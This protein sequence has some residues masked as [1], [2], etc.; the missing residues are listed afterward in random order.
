MSRL[1]AIA[2]MQRR[3]LHSAARE[4]ARMAVDLELAGT[5]MAN[6]K[7]A[8]QSQRAEAK[9]RE[10]TMYADLCKD[11]VRSQR[12]DDVMTDVQLIRKHTLERERDLLEA[13][14]QYEAARVRW[15]AAH[16]RYRQCT[17][18]ME[19]FDG[20]VSMEQQA[21]QRAAQSAEDAILEEV[22]DLWQKHHD[23][24]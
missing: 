13:E 11:L 10:M 24:S 5:R 12:L 15:D 1:T 18:R 8:L 7:A 19:K 22:T 2:H 3:R 21:L 23:Y 6:C 4:L 16:A 17:I 20:L 14:R 9:R